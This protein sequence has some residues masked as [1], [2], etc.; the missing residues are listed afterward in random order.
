MPS[1]FDQLSYVDQ[2]LMDL[3]KYA[4]HGHESYCSNVTTTATQAA[5]TFRVFGLLEWSRP[6][7]LKSS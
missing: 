3:Q 6:G 1:F 4:A 2:Q 7:F 5:K